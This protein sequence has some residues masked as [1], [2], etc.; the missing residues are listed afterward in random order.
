LQRSSLT[1]SSA[2]GIKVPRRAD[3]GWRRADKIGE[4]MT[5]Y[6]EMAR[7]R[8]KVRSPCSTRH[9]GCS[10]AEDWK[11]LHRCVSKES[12]ENEVAR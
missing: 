6:A 11:P 10:R 9:L 1:A 2:S 12:S 5:S 4:S 3:R 7:E 8:K